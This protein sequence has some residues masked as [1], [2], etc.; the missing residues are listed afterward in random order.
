MIAKVLKKIICLANNK[1]QHKV[2]INLDRKCPLK[3]D[4]LLQN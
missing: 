2:P 3:Y 4:M 1:S